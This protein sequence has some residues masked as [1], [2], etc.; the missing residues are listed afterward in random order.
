MNRPLTETEHED[1]LVRLCV[2][3]D[4]DQ[5]YWFPLRA[6]ETSRNDIIAFCYPFFERY[7]G[8]SGV[9]DILQARDIDLLIETR[10]GGECTWIPTTDVEFNYSGLEG[11]WTTR[12]FDWV[13]YASHE[14][15]ITFAGQW[16][17]EEL[18]ANWPNWRD[19]IYRS[20]FEEDY[21]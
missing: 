17:L 8:D 13:I 12:E 3:W 2:L 20:P 16:L 10:E 18:K 14:S 9:R 6:N 7:V 15:S 19:C 11:Y 5:R 21:A 1:T 4:I